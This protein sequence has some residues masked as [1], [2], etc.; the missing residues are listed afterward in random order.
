MKNVLILD[1]ETTGVDRDKD[2]VIE[3]GCILWSVEHRT[4]LSIYSNLIQGE[5]NAAEHINGITPAVLRQHPAPATRVFKAVECLAERAD[6]VVAHQADFD[7]A[8]CARHSDYLASKS[9]VCTKEDL[10]W[11]RAKPGTS[12][13]ATALAHGVPVFQA[14]RAISDCMLIARL[15][16][17]H[18]DIDTRLEAALAHSLIPKHRYVAIT[19]YEER[20]LPKQA[21]FRW[22]GERKEWWRVL[23]EEDAAKLPFP[24]VERGDG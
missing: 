18:P 14:H 11:P 16:E 20:D 23:N 19:S 2:R 1:T 3:V 22:D 5:D 15:F 12:L 21:G 17:A 4:T 8:F 6:I 7:R 13:V 24:T 9:W 10:V